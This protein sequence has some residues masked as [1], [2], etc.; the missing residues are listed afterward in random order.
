VEGEARDRTGVDGQVP[1]Q[2]EADGGDGEDGQD[3]GDED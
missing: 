3:I 2:D 1:R